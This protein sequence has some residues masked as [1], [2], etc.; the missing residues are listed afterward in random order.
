MNT[1]RKN[2]TLHTCFK[3]RLQAGEFTPYFQPIVSLED[4]RVVGF[5]MLARRVLP[6]GLIIPPINSFPKW[7]VR[8]C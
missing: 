1:K 7:N 2:A 5:E 8:A 4:E 3:K 6:D